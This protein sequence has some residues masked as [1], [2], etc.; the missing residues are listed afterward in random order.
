[1]QWFH[2]LN[3]FLQFGWLLLHF[4]P[5]GSAAARAPRARLPAHFSTLVER[6]R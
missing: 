2:S 1:V 5:R 3:L 4:E 6:R